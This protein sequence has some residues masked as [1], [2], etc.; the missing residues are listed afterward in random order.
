MSACI[1]VMGGGK[2][3]A[4]TVLREEARIRQALRNV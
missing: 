4:D 2:T 1:E 3:Y